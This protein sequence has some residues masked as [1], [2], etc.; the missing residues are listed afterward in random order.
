MTANERFARGASEAEAAEEGRPSRSRPGVPYACASTRLCQSSIGGPFSSHRRARRLARSASSPSPPPGSPVF[1][2]LTPRAV[3][4]FAVS[5][6]VRSRADAERPRDTRPRRDEAQPKR[7]RAPTSERDR[8]APLELCADARLVRVRLCALYRAHL[9]TNNA[10]DRAREA[11]TKRN[12]EGE[13]RRRGTGTT[14]SR[15]ARLAP[16]LGPPA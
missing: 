1:V 2:F 15:P 7:D 4:S 3:P 5:R 10:R 13:R 12:E 11:R 9:C 6:I 8:L 14:R 16:H